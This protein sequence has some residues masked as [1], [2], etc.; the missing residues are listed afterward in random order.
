MW[1]YLNLKDEAVPVKPEV[2]IVIPCYN[3]EPLLLESVAEIQKVMDTT[4]YSYEMVFVDDASC[5]RTPELIKRLCAQH[6]NCRYLLHRNNVGRGGTVNDGLRLAKG[7]IAGFLDIDLEVHAR[8]IPA[9]LAEI[10]A[11]ECSVATVRRVYKLKLTPQAILRTLLSAGYRRIVRTA[12][13]LPLSDTES[14]FKFFDR[15]SIMPVIEDT[16][17]TGWFW[18]TEIMALSLRHGLTVKEIPG[19]FQRRV[20]K[21]SS[22]KIVADTYAY[23]RALTDFRRRRA[24]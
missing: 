19:L 2:S 5:D 3:E 10:D 6:P 12:L 18:D 17:D 4:R 24:A 9:L 11:G 22:V 21:T 15:Q 23:V 14:G 1:P 7:R 13:R 8:Y 16:V 20:D